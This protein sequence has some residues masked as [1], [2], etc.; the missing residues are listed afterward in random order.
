MDGLR[1]YRPGSPAARIHWAALARGAGLLERRLRAES[2]SRPLVVLDARGAARP[3]DLD[4]AV[5]AA[6]SITYALSRGEGCSLLLPGERR[7]TA[8]DG[9][10]GSWT[11]AHARL[12]LVDGGPAAA[13]PFLAGAGVRQGPTF[14]VAAR[15][16][17]RMP[18][19]ADGVARAARVLVVPGSL[20]GRT[21]RFE[22]AGCSG[23]ELRAQR[24]PG[25]GAGAHAGVAS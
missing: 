15:R 21:A 4:A 19:A 24:G 22:V 2:D 9:G 11:A 8:L 25:V 13:A 18:A 23:Y 1:P 10:P 6:A 16:L 20:P 7:P 3:E 14:Y 17:T 12:A 5:R